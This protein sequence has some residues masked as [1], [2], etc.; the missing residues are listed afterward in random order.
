VRFGGGIVVDGDVEV[1]S[2]GST[3]LVVPPGTRLTG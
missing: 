3:P 1:R 2:D